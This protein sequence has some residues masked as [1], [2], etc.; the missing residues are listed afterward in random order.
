[1]QLDVKYIASR[2]VKGILSVL[3]IGEFI[4]KQSRGV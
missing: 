3:V 1:M 4:Q 2:E